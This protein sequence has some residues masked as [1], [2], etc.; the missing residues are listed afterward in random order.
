MKKKLFNLKIWVDESKCYQDEFGI[1]L[2]PLEVF[3]IKISDKPEEE[4]DNNK[5]NINSIS[6]I[7]NRSEIINNSSNFLEN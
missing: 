7:N 1:I 6:N 2:E 4:D 3:Q 5:N